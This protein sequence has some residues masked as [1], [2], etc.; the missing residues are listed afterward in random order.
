MTYI[1]RPLP[2]Q[3]IVQFN[4]W[5]IFNNT[6]YLKF[7]YIKSTYSAQS[8]GGP[9]WY[10]SQLRTFQFA[11]YTREVT[12][13]L[14]FESD[15]MVG[16]DSPF[17]LPSGQSYTAVARIIFDPDSPVVTWGGPSI[18]LRLTVP[19]VYAEFDFDVHL[20]AY[21]DPA[22]LDGRIRPI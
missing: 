14:D 1:P 10:Q 9:G 2:A 15:V 3:H 19:D 22:T 18:T 16:T 21:T 7:S 17:S 8:P 4:R 11:A 5:S 12:S 20:P 6:L 13:P